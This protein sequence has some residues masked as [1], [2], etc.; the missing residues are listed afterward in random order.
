MPDSTSPTPSDPAPLPGGGV[1]VGGQTSIG[2]DVVGRDKI[3]HN[4]QNIYQ[5]ALTAAE[6]AAQDR[7]LEAQ[8]LA[9]GVSELAQQLQARAS[10]TADTAAGSPYKGLLEYRLG[11]AE[12]FFGRDRAVRELLAVME[13]GSLTILHSESGAGKTSLLQAGIS[14]RII[15]AGHLPLYL[16]PY[17]ANPAYAIK[18]AF[19]S[20]PGQTPILA[21]APLRDFL[22]QVCSVLG[23][24][25]R[26]YIFL[27]QFEEFFTQLDEPERANFVGELAECLEDTGLNARWVLALRTEHFGNLAN[28]RPRIRNP[29][30]NDYR[31]N[32]LRRDEAEEVITKP[33]AARGI[34]FE[35][36]LIGDLLNDLG[37]SEIAPP[38]LQLVCSALYH[39]LEP[40]ETFISRALYD[41]EGGAAGILRG[42]L[43]RVLSRDLLP[44]QRAAAR[45][46]LES[47]ITS[48]QQRIIRPHSELVAELSARGITPTTL[49]TILQQLVDSRLIRPQETESGLAYELAHDY[50][51]NEIKL[52]PEVQ[53]RKAAQE[54]LEQEV[55]AYRRYKTLLAPER[56]AVI[57]QYFND[58]TISLEAAQLINESKVAVLREEVEREESR[59]R[60]VETARKLA[61]EQQK[62][63][64]EQRQRA[65]D[66]ERT[67][68]LLHGRARLLAAALGVTVALILFAGYLS[69]QIVRIGAQ[70]Q[71]NA[72]A[73]RT[74]EARALAQA[75]ALATEAVARA[76]E[77][78]ARA[79]AEAVAKRNEE[80]ALAN[81]EKARQQELA[82]VS[83]QLAAQAR[84][85]FGTQLDLALLLSLEANNVTDTVEARGAL[86]DGLNY[87][88]LA[89]HF[90][91]FPDSF[92]TASA[93]SPDGQWL[94]TGRSDGRVVLWNANTGSPLPTPLAAE[95]LT[96]VTALAFNHSGARL[97]VGYSNATIGLWDVSQLPQRPRRLPRLIGHLS[98][99][100][101]I[102]F[103]FDDALLA[104]ADSASNIILWDT[105]SAQNRPSVLAYFS[106]NLG[107]VRRIA[108]SPDGSSLAS[109]GV[110]GNVIL[111]DAND[112]V[113]GVT[114]AIT[115]NDHNGIPVNAVAFS[116]DGA[117]LASGADDG[118]IIIRDLTDRS[119]PT[120]FLQHS[121][122]VNSL[123]FSPNSDM[124]ATASADGLVSLWNYFNSYPFDTLRGQGGGITQV[125]F[126]GD[127]GTLVSTSF[128][129]SA[130]LWNMGTDQLLNRTIILNYPPLY[131]AFAR[132]G[133]RAVIGTESIVA[134]W[135]TATGTIEGEFNPGIDITAL[136]LDPDGNM[137]V[138]AS[139]GIVQL[140]D[141]T[142]SATSF[143]HQA[144]LDIDEAEVNTLAFSPDGSRLAVGSCYRE[145]NSSCVEGWILVWD[146]H[147]GTLIAELLGHSGEVIAMDFDPDGATLASAGGGSI[148]VWDL[149]TGD[150]KAP[151]RH[152]PDSLVATVSFSPDGKTVAAGSN[153]GAL[154]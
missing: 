27:D 111:W 57:E 66:Q 75:D 19:I 103:R 14:S 61:E 62:L 48:E 109:A 8:R 90:F 31:L 121:A 108:F 45:R 78:A 137:L 138:V 55:R 11:D 154:L 41:R 20:D 85:F 131:S 144:D 56:L 106:A 77:A 147:G 42:H 17:N 21:T 82:A 1:T 118:S 101:A 28:L 116:G 98:E 81:E 135:D 38:Q 153:A 130:V 119:I 64:D 141:L 4:I 88:P 13:G 37:K 53:S 3:V 127:G 95:S 69:T 5:R 47:L 39:E 113:N 24:H 18:R 83:R 84:Q 72:D 99:V 96:S 43:E 63:A 94:A 15:G 140:W 151:E 132:R 71:A 59:Q 65:E 86:R 58:L 25:T 112:P 92:I 114:A 122:P 54:L 146:V 79:T 145:E 142:A 110:D 117:L 126:S 29:F 40:G 67:A 149:Q 30:E 128:D 143:V 139:G 134:L 150:Q 50:L 80:I 49:D 133:A 10:D 12:I 2:G 51:L 70:V 74:A 104:S 107:A 124:F 36:G 136:A 35:E 7:H 100:T 73:A 44:E 93:L 129:G 123:A 60:E 125:A 9:H 52:D 89:T 76:T 120:R 26:L 16:R 87:S 6:E 102:D 23:P 22:R 33:A 32:R 152:L 68:K 115:Y 46:L 97:A 105:A 34:T 91:R 148:I